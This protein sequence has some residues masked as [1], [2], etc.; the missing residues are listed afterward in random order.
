MTNIEKFYDKYTQY[1]WDRLEH[2]KTT[3]A[4]TMRAF[5]DYILNPP[6]KILDVGGG[7]GR[8]AVALALQNNDVTLMDLSRNCLEFAKDKAKKAGV[9]RLCY[10]QGTAT[11]LSQFPHQEFDV[12]LLMG[13]LYHLLSLNNRKLA[14]KESRNVLKSDGLIFAAF[15][16]RFAPIRFAA[17]YD[18]LWIIESQQ[19]LEELLTT[20]ILTASSDR[21]GFTDAYYSHPS[22]IIPF[23]ESCGFE[24]LNL[25]S[26]EGIISLI[27]DKISNLDN[28]LWLKWVDLNYRLGMDPSVYGT[29]KHLLYVG[30]RK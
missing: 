4:I 25:I 13:P 12:V 14:L 23:M 21:G 5:Q 19:R 27:D 17:K 6:V 7:P 1:E 9:K 28:E 11:D 16:T 2:N 30:R 24:T 15:I 22:E 29:A 18:P 10:I 8:Y 26:C 20:G 3:F